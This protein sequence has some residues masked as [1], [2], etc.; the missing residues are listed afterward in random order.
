MHNEY[1]CHNKLKDVREPYFT[2]SAAR[3]FMEPSSPPSAFM[4]L[5]GAGAGAGGA[6]YD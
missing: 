6:S 1:I 4:E 5:R 2:G 3:C